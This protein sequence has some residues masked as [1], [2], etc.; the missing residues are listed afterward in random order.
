MNHLILLGCWAF[1]YWLIKRD[2]V[3][4]IGV[5]R[6]IWI[7]TLWVGVLASRPI[8]AWLGLGSG[9]TLEGSPIDRIFFF[10]MIIAALVVLSRRSV[11]WGQFYSRNWPLVLFYGYLLGTVLWAN[12]P[13]SSFKRWTK[14]FGNVFIVMVILTEADPIQAV[15]TVFVRCAY[16]LVPLSIVFIRY[17]P[18]LGRRYSIH[19]GE[20]EITGVTTQKNS[21]GAMILVCG[22]VFIWDWLER[23]RPGQA[24]R[25]RVDRLL[26]LAWLAS[27][28]WLI[29]LSDSKTSITCL[30]L[31]SAIIAAVRL[32]VLHRRISA[33]GIY[34]LIAAGAFFLF[35][36]MFGLSAMVISN[37]G[38]DMT[39]TGRTDVWRELLGVHT[40]PVFG[41]GFMSFWDDLSYRARLPD[42]VAFSA[43]N[44]Y[45]EIYLAGGVIGVAL[46]A[47]LIIATGV[48]INQAL[49]SLEVYAVVRFA[50]FVAVLLANF[51]ESNFA[52]MTPL[53][54][55]FLIAAIGE[56][57][58]LA[59]VQWTSLAPTASEDGSPE[60]DAVK[61]A[62]TPLPY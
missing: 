57:P 26:P 13:V 21:L 8:S 25:S 5:S 54:V 52:C 18:D 15:R 22:I 43:H 38:R 58:S 30:L 2:S 41:T 53:G 37:L 48:R 16:A 7:P 17:F 29:Y 6:A 1:V 44:G 33:M 40:D 56:V 62:R 9:D 3:H 49:A 19:S 51:S 45:L 32:P 61:T 46:L 23:T 36:S 60:L 34:L 47:V 42:W 55:L 28:S 11:P 50:I 24:P 35:D 39:F 59:T 31:A 12:S 27:A 4:R 20:L 14:E 10:G